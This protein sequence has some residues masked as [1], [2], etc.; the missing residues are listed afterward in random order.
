MNTM[1]LHLYLTFVAA[2][3]VIVIVPGPTVTLIIA[4]SLRHGTR[5]GMLNIAGSQ[6]GFACMIA[7]VLAGLASLINA[8]GA[9]FDYVRLAGAAYL[10]WLGIKLLRSSGSLAEMQNAPKPRVGFLAQGFLVAMSNPKALLLFGALFPQFIDP[11][12]DYV[13]QVLLLGITAMVIAFVF[14][15]SYAVLTGRAGVLLSQRRI[16]LMSRASGLCLIGGGAWL[17]L[18]RSR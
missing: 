12:S 17:A 15:S 13:P 5:A 10:V 2:C 8:M 4:N 6:L 1:A 18:A 3:A 9:W 14:D 11:A 16:R 7:I